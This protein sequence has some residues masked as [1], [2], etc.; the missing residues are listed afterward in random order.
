MP[1][2]GEISPDWPYGYGFCHCGCGQRTT[3]ADRNHANRGA[4]KG[5]PRRFVTGHYARTYHSPIPFDERFWSKVDRSGGPDACWL[6]TKGTFNTGYGSVGTGPNSHI[7]RG[8]HCVAWELAYGPIPDGLCILHR[9][10]NRACC[11]PAHL[12]LGTRADNTSDML[13]KERE[14]RGARLSRKLTEADV[15]SIRS[16]VASGETRASMAHEY[17]LS[18]AGIQS[19]IL[20]KTWRHV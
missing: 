15:L 6:W 13:A 5:V 9:C 3:I 17:G 18:W 2:I 7:A 16:R 4:I 19:I 12:F 1:D 8:A 20:H 10:D 11:N 14:A